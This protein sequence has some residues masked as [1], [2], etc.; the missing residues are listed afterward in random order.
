VQRAV[1]R[2][3][4]ADA[5]EQGRERGRRVQPG[6]ERGRLGAVTPEVRTQP[7]SA[8]QGERQGV[9]LTT[10][11]TRAPRQLGT[12]LCLIVDPGHRKSCTVRV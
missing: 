10:L 4:V 5:L 12:R 6:G 7:F 8:L 9:Q 3:R 11:Q 2:D 1:G